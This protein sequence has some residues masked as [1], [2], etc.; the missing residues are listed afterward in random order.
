MMNDIPS[1][2]KECI[3]KKKCKNVT[4]G[5]SKCRQKLGIEQKAIPDDVDYGMIILWYYYNES[6]GLYEKGE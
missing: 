6:K 4:R 1:S 5:S 2:C 3:Y